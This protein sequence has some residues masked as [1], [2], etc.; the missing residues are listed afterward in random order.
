[1]EK[2]TIRFY[3][4]VKIQTTN[5]FLIHDGINDVWLPKSQVK[6]MRRIPGHD[7]INDYEF[8]IPYWLAKRKHII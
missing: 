3:G 1:M 5:A 8:R 4:E 2:E 7:Q 6:S